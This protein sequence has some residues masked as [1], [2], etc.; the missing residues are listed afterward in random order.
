MAPL[1][2]VTTT[3]ASSIWIDFM[4]LLLLWQVAG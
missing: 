1:A 4:G 2:Q 3:T